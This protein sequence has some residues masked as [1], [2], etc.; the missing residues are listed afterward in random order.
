PGQARRHRT[1]SAMPPTLGACSVREVAVGDG[2]SFSTPVLTASPSVRTEC[3]REVDIQS[4]SKNSYLS[5]MARANE[6]AR[7]VLRVQWAF[8]A[9]ACVCLGLHLVFGA[10]WWLLAIVFAVG[11]LVSATI[12]LRFV[13][14]SR[15][16]SRVLHALDAADSKPP[17]ELNPGFSGG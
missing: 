15:T 3:E 10:W 9:A 14:Q 6:K 16:A 12:H 1:L 2:E 7:T 4:I 13:S 17:G 11:A 8:L 5:E